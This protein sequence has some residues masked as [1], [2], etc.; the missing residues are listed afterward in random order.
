[1][2]GL[3]RHDQPMSTSDYQIEQNAERRAGLY[4]L[5]IFSLMMLANLVVNATT[6]NMEYSRSDEPYVSALAWFT[7][8]TSIIFILALFPVV[9]WWENRF[10]VSLENWKQALPAHLLGLIAFSFIHVLAMALTRESLHPI[11]FGTEYHFFNNPLTDFLYEIRKD[12]L[13]YASILLAIVCFRA[14]E[15]HR[16]DAAAARSEARTSHRVTL[17]CGGRTLYLEANAF[18]YAKAAG[19]YVEARFG[20]KQHLARMTLSELENLLT[21]AHVQAKR[22]HRSWLVNA[23]EIAQTQPT[24]EGD[25]TI[26]LNNGET[27]PGSR[28]YRDRLDAA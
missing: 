23:Q 21:E 18:L 6:I 1:M 17:K 24:G 5:I 20:D 15:F 9:K 4:A 25:I 14:I 28:R 22:V 7:E 19:N 10:Q 8:T 16:M 12:A 13:S 26:T 2:A 3:D 11:F 27:I